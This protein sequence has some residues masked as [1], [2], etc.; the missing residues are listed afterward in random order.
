MD[1][2]R[3]GLHWS[4]CLVYTDDIVLFTK[5]VE[6]HITLMEDVLSRLRRAGLKLK[7]AKC[8]MFNDSVTFLGHQVSRQGTAPD[9][10]NIEKVQAFPSPISIKDV[11]SFLS[12]ASYY[13]RFVPKFSAIAEPLI[14]L[15]R[16]D[17]DFCWNKDCDSA[18]LELPGA[19]VKC[20]VLAFPDFNESFILTTDA[21]YTAV[22]AV[23]SQIQQGK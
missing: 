3:T 14:S 7:P 8:Q 10:R 13:R 5:T 20:P 15:T 9:P 11:K 22:V 6:G 21:L 18:F 19:L 4:A 12:L 17:V 1:L 23:L 16:K 2:V